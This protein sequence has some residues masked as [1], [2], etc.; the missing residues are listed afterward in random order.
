MGM[1]I[2]IWAE[3]KKDGKWI[4][5]DKRIFD[6]EYD[7]ISVVPFGWRSSSMA[8][9]LGEDVK[10]RLKFIKIVE[11]RGL[12]EDSEYLNTPLSAPEYYIYSGY[13]NGTAY[14]IKESY[15]CDINNFGHSWILLKELLEFDY[16]QQCL[17]GEGT[18][19]DY[20]ADRFFTH[21]E[22]LKTLGAPEDVR[23]V[24]YFD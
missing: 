24:F 13:N 10:W 19:R 18:H 9:I 15:E 22:Q 5:N 4:E 11:A 12:P 20:L 3:V 23:I 16:D 17:D 2:S 21:L 7:P 8:A 14:T 6:D 1:D